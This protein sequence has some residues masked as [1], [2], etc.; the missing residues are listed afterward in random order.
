MNIEE[1]EDLLYEAE[2]VRKLKNKSPNIE[3]ENKCMKAY[4][5]GKL[6][7]LPRDQIYQRHKEI[8]NN[9]REKTMKKILVEY[10]R[11]NGKKVGVVVATNKHEIGWSQCSKKDKFDKKRGLEIAIGRARIGTSTNPAKIKNKDIVT[12]IIDKMTDRAERYFKN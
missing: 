6:K 3:F 5:E 1:V 7:L 11:F 9:L 12:P 10:V 2:H 4:E 8:M